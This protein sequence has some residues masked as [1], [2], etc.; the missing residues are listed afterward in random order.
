MKTVGNLH[1][2]SQVVFQSI[3][4]HIPSKHHCISA[5][6]PF[7]I[8]PELLLSVLR[9]QHK[10]DENSLQEEKTAIVPVFYGVIKPQVYCR[11]TTTTTPQS[12]LTQNKSFKSTKS[13]LPPSW[14]IGNA[15]ELYLGGTRHSP[16]ISQ[17]RLRCSW[18][19]VPLQMNAQGCSL[20]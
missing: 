11:V 1:S 7:L 12:R 16:N 8:H 19:S 20:K 9:E 5:L 15:L 14:Y 4:S 2:V 18:F 13:C 3:G 6:L 17:Y 10:D